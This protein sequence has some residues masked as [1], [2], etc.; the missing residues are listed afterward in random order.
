MSDPVSRLPSIQRRA[1]FR[2]Q[3]HHEHVEL[4]HQASWIVILS[5][6]GTLTRLGLTA[7]SDF[8]GQV[9]PAVTWAQ[10]VGSALMGFLVKDD[11]LFPRPPNRRYDALHVGL[12]TGYCGS[13]TTFSAWMLQIYEALSNSM[14]APHRGGYNVIALLSQV[15][16][17]LAASIAAYKLGSHTAYWLR[18]W[19]PSLRHQFPVLENGGDAELVLV[20]FVTALAAC[21][22]AAAIVVAAVRPD[23]RGKASIAITLAPAG[24]LLRWQVSRQLNARRQ[25]FPVGTFLVNIVGSLLEGIFYLLQHHPRDKL[26]C[27]ML[28]GLQDGFCGCLTTVST[29]VVEL[30]VMSHGNAW[31]YGL[32]SVF[33]AVILLIL[34]DGVDFWTRQ[35]AS[36]YV[37]CS[38]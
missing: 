24:A 11:T 20:A 3:I 30:H 22:S 19:R 4:L 2:T 10:F 14:R 21:C 27:V 5:I 7:L 34:V 9:I 13:T 38:Y 1:I 35:G 33:V 26:A 31:R 23:W 16:V 12:A 36:T 25:D 28:Q 8:P 15:L 17:Q 37:K 29:F 6:L 18:E 32:L